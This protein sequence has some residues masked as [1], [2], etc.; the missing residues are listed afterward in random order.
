MNL[1]KHTKGILVHNGYFF[2][3]DLMK[4]FHKVNKSEKNAAMGHNK[5]ISDGTT[6]GPTV[7]SNLNFEIELTNDIKT[8]PQ[9]DQD[10]VESISRELERLY[11]LYDKLMVFKPMEF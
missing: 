1:H 2:V 4:H 8:D 11:D 7:I 5:P 3:S 10:Q 9:L 6:T